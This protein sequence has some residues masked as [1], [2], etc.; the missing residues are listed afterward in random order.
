[1]PGLVQV[2]DLED[3]L[4]DEHTEEQQIAEPEANE[5]TARAPESHTGIPL[6]EP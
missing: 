5:P 3:G 1:M 2:S 4:G 6:P